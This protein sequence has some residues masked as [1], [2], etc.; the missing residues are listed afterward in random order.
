MHSYASLALFYE[1]GTQLVSDPGF[2]LVRACHQAGVPVVPVPGD[3]AVLAAL[4][5]A[6]LPTDRFVFEGFLPN[7]G[8]VRD[9]ALR[10]ILANRATSV[11]FEAPH[12]LLALLESIEAAGAGEREITLCRELTKRFETVLRDS[13]SGLRQRVADDTDQQRGEVVLV[14]AGAPAQAAADA[15]LLPL[16]RLLLEDLPASRA[17]R[18]LAAHSGRKRQ[19][20]YEWLGRL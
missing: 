5:V 4:A 3:S 7:K 8:S 20:I 6:G 1:S 18:I 14:L 9:E 10:N 16:A 19:E 11:L 12:R 17:A 15:E 13:V 2:R